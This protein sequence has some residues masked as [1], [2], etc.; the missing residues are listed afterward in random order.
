MQTISTIIEEQSNKEQTQLV[1]NTSRF[2]TLCLHCKNEICL[3]YHYY[4]QEKKKKEYAV[5]EEGSLITDNK[6]RN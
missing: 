5:G 3:V 6:T 4:S 2:L 1:T